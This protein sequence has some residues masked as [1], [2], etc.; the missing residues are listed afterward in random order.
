[1]FNQYGCGSCWAVTIATTM[2]DCLVV[3]GVVDWCPMISPTYIMMITPFAQFLQRQCLGGSIA[4]AIKYL[5]D[6]QIKL[7]DSSCVDYSWCDKVWCS[8]PNFNDNSNTFKVA[9]YYNTMLNKTI[10]PIH[11]CY[12]DTPKWAFKLDKF[13]KYIPI[14][15]SI[16]QVRNIV[17]GHI[18]T[19]GPVIGSFVILK[20]FIDDGFTTF[21][22]GVYFDRADYENYYKTGKLAFSPIQKDNITL[23]ENLQGTH[24]V[25][26]VGWGVAKNIQYDNDKFG[27]VPYW[28]VRNSWGDDWGDDGYFKMAM[29]PFN[30]MSQFER[31]TFIKFKNK[32]SP[33]GPL[34]MILL[35]KATSKPEILTFGP[36]GSMS[37]IYRSCP[38]DYY[39]ANPYQIRNAH[40]GIAYKNI[41]NSQKPQFP[42][43]SSCKFGPNPHMSDSLFPPFYPNIF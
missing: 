31:P 29:Y 6:N 37:N 5:S 16:E 36:L 42:I 4:N 21:N 7:S 19:Y 40:R 27:D 10:P 3:S 8:N 9:D 14:D 41:F 43:T 34:G 20:Q 35:I 23:E 2:S 11:G 17:K 30:L 26:I 1:V 22:G 38:S 13:I 33:S 15:F 32:S 28:L 39:S 12:Y 25:S 18:L 24:S